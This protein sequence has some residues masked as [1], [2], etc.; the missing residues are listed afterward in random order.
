MKYQSTNEKKKRCLIKAVG[1]KLSLS[2]L[3]NPAGQL[4]SK[5]LKPLNENLPWL[6]EQTTGLF[7]IVEGLHCVGVDCARQ[8][9]FDC[10]WATAL[11]LSLDSLAYCGFRN[12]KEMR[13][14]V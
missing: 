2:K 14:I 4:L 9:I 12:V 13:Q 5:T 1:T 7:L 8:L 10:G 6:M 3:C 11:K